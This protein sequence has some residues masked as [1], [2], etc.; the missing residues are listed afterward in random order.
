MQHMSTAN[1]QTQPERL[2]NL[3]HIAHA[4]G[5]EYHFVY[6]ATEKGQLPR[7]PYFAGTRPLW[8]AAMLPEI[9]KALQPIV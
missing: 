1:S 8:P 2:L 7:P 3:R 4:L 5:V 9:K 6:R